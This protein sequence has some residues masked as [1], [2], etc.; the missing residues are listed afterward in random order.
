MT[1]PDSSRTVPVSWSQPLVSDDS[2]G[3]VS[4]IRTHLPGQRF[5]FGTTE[6]RYRFVD[7]AGNFAICRFYVSVVLGG[8]SI[9]SNKY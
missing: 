2:M 7:L 1:V 5:S 6:V 3:R 4:R 8:K 9:M